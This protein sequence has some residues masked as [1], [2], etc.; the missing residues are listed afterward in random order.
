MYITDLTLPRSPCLFTKALSFEG[1]NIRT[2]GY[3]LSG[4]VILNPL[5][6]HDNKVI[7]LLYPCLFKCHQ[8]K[9]SA[10]QV[11]SKCMASFK[12]YKSSLQ[13]IVS[14]LEIHVSYRLLQNKPKGGK[15]VIYF[16]FLVTIYS[17]KISVNT[18]K[19]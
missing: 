3:S 16:L 9:G 1:S 6:R 15:Y 13:D 12:N 19:W 17:L 7:A 8:V 11:G 2:L 14:N 4:I 10:G 5:N 18:E